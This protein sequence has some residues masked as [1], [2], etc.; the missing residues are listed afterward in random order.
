MAQE[1]VQI[2]LDA[3]D[4]TRRAFKGIQGSI[5]KMRA[6]LFSLQSAFATIGAGL[7]VKSFISVGSEVENLSLRFNFLFGSV[8]EGK[9]AFDGLVKF[10]GKVPFSLQEIAMASGNLAVVSKDAKELTHNLKLAGN[11]AAV[12]GLDFRTVGEQLQRSFSSGIASADLFRE[13]GVNALLGFKAGARVSIDETIAKFEEVFG[14]G[15]KFGRA[16]EVLG[17]TLTGTLSMLTDKLFNFRL[18]TNR[19]GFF[20]FVKQ[21][22]V[23]INKFLDS[24]S[25]ALD[26]FAVKL[27]NSLI[28]ITRNV[29]IGSAII[30]DSIAPVFI[31][32][33]K[34]MGGLLGILNAL[35]EGIKTLGIVGFLMLGGK[36][37]LLVLFLGS[38]F[39]SLR[40]MIG[41]ISSAYGSMI[42]GMAKSM[43]F[44]KI[45]SEE[46][47]KENLKTVKEFKDAA[48]RLQTPFAQLN[49]ETKAISN[50]MGYFTKLLTEFLDGLEAKALLSAKQI[51][52]IN[53]EIE[54]MNKSAKGSGET[55][56]S[57]EISLKKISEEL[58]KKTN[59]EFSK[60]NE[61]IA[62]G[63]IKGVKGISRGLAESLVL[64]KKLSDTLRNIASKIIVNIISKLIEEQLM[65]LVNLGIEKLKTSE[66]AKQYALRKKM[67]QSSSSGGIL[68]TIVNAIGSIFPGSSNTGG[69]GGGGGYNMAEGGSVKG[70]QPITIGERGREM[71]IPSSDG[72]VVPNHQMGGS[73]NVNF[74]IIANDTKDFDR[75]LIER[76]SIISNLIN[77]ALNQQGKGSLV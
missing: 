50:N 13:R 10:A 56:Q 14:E 29:L 55:L 7:L 40:S 28:S 52:I 34:A 18:E 36:G 21:G 27:S 12:T 75:L 8:K 15:G 41:S 44:L 48:S 17:T 16:A 61:T 51:E 47:F 5:G 1:R 68:G 4:N 67:N 19:A 77:Q 74:T 11:I 49:K 69:G 72:Q 65:L 38:I 33:A 25:K 9:K 76:R 66:L 53:K 59:A 20:D 6:K 24:N 71:F 45:I 43:R 42:E 22:L 30:I 31:F 58:L 60:I 46:T 73:T 2:R 57:M 70:G 3:V 26:L 62:T 54:K 37:K 23:E 35:P 63:I 39:D 64:G 32:V